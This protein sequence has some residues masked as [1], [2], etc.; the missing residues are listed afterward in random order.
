MVTQLPIVQVEVEVKVKVEVK[1]VVFVAVIFGN[2]DDND[3]GGVS[4]EYAPNRNANIALN[5]LKKLN[6]KQ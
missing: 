4:Q 1:V 5:K 6:N 3:G 2:G